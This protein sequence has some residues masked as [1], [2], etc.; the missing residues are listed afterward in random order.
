M[1]I[2][3]PIHSI[4]PLARWHVAALGPDQYDIHCKR[5]PHHANADGLS[6]LPLEG[7]PRAEAAV[8]ATCFN[9]SQIKTLPLTS[10]QLSKATRSDPVHSQ[11]LSF[12]RS[13][14]QEHGNSQLQPFSNHKQ[15]L[16]VEGN[17]LLW[18]T[19]VIIP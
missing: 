7:Q 4:P 9:L 18:E 16:S 2:L 11:V 3:S 6:R 17:C 13:E 15:E 8:D 10:T 14:W 12:T 19:C 1:T 5:I